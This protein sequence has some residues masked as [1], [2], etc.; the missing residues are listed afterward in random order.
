MGGELLFKCPYPS[1]KPHVF[2][3]IGFPI[4]VCEWTKTLFFYANTYAYFVK[5]YVYIL[6]SYTLLVSEYVIFNNYTVF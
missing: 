2:E 4:K 6:L 3:N 5:K 1:L